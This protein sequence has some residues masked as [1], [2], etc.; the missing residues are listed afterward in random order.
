MIKQE[1]KAEIHAL[2][3]YVFVYLET[4]HITDKVLR[5]FKV[6]RKYDDIHTGKINCVD[7]SS[8]GE[9]AVSSSDDDSIMLYDIQQGK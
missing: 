1:A 2:F 6:A 9:N 7:Y 8:N 4:M 3:T 5:S